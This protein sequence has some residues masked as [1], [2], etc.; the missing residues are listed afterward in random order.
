MLEY[1]TLVLHLR[2]ACACHKRK[3]VEGTLHLQSSIENHFIFP[4]AFAE[5]G[6]KNTDRGEIKAE[7]DPAKPVEI[8][9]Q[10]IVTP[11]L[12]I[13]S[14]VPHPLKALAAVAVRKGFDTR[15]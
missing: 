7:K 1:K 2:G 13:T 8:G 3:S 12:T 4:G 11:G 6:P 9:I 14:L 15:A 10:E 5:F